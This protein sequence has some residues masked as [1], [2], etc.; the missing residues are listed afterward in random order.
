VSSNARGHYVARRPGR[1]P[2]GND[3]VVYGNGQ[4]KNGPKFGGKLSFLKVT[5]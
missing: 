5:T 1:V 2:V 3:E 4:I